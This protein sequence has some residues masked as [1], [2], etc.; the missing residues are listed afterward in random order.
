MKKMIH[1][2]M[3]VAVTVLVLA[4]GVANSPK[5]VAIQFTK[6]LTSGEYTKA[7]ELGTADTKQMIKFMASMVDEDTVKKN[8]RALKI[9]HVSTEVDGDTAVV[10]L[11]AGQEVKPISLRKVEGKWLVELE[12]DSMNMDKDILNQ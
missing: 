9:T 5:D 4:C 10:V 6:Y 11:S 8:S 7:A 3:V 12:K 2:M 1:V